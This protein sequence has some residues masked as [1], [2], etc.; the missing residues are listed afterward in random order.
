MKT[1]HGQNTNDT[2]REASVERFLN[3]DKTARE[4]YCIKDPENKSWPTFLL[5]DCKSLEQQ[6]VDNTL[7]APKCGN[8]PWLGNQNDKLIDAMNNAACRIHEDRCANF[9]CCRKGGEPSNNI[10]QPIQPRNSIGKCDILHLERMVLEI[11]HYPNKEAELTELITEMEELGC[12]IRN[13]NSDTPVNCASLQLAI[14]E[15][16]I[17]SQQC[18]DGCPDLKRNL[19]ALVLKSEKMAWAVGA[20]KRELDA[21]TPPI[22]NNTAQPMLIRE[23]DTDDCKDLRLRLV[24]VAIANGADKREQILRIL[25]ELNRKG[26]SVRDSHE[27]NPVDCAGLSVAL[28]EVTSWS[29]QCGPGCPQL[30]KQVTELVAKMGKKGCSGHTHNRL[31]STA[32]PFQLRDI[33]PPPPAQHEEFCN[34]VAES[35]E[36]ANKFQSTNSKDEKLPQWFKEWQG[37]MSNLEEQ[38]TCAKSSNE[39]APSNPLTTPDLGEHPDHGTICEAVMK[40]RNP[41]DSLGQEYISYH[42]PIPQWILDWNDFMYGLETQLGCIE[43]MGEDAKPPSSQEVTGRSTSEGSSAPAYPGKGESQEKVQS[44][45][46]DCVDNGQAVP[47]GVSRPAQAFQKLHPRLNCLQL[48]SDKPALETSTSSLL[49]NRH[50]AVRHWDEPCTVVDKLQDK[51]PLL[52]PWMDAA[53]YHDAFG[54]AVPEWLYG[55]SQYILQLRRHLKCPTDGFTGLLPPRAFSSSLLS[56]STESDVSPLLVRETVDANTCLLIFNSRLNVEDVIDNW[57]KHGFT[58]VPDWLLGWDDFMEGL[59]RETGCEPPDEDTASRLVKRLSLAEKKENCDNVREYRHAVDELRKEQR[60]QGEVTPQWL[61]SWQASVDHTE[62]NLG[63]ET[64]A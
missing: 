55:W 43:R 5:Q 46:H 30:A 61:M 7:W 44:L 4:N 64:D 57:K 58:D 54:Q 8:C 39:S 28:A 42:Q 52:K 37:F 33:V 20:L 24:S 31:N 11:G 41:I 47:K 6:F 18:E 22:L 1:N 2:Q 53:G 34:A 10:S 21:P 45:I 35:H 15:L 63:C 19:A 51:D 59:G 62:S 48:V 29:M 25:A 17:W 60:K 23:S 12:E 13:Q 56:S 14:A 36:V 3:L 32:Y 40:S 27:E 26:C 49:A 50:I 9:T 16:T 38:L